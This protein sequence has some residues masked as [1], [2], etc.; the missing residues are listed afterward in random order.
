MQIAEDFL[1]PPG[2]QKQKPWKPLCTFVRF[3]ASHVSRKTRYSI[4]FVCH[5][6]KAWYEW[7]LWLFTLSHGRTTNI[8]KRSKVSA[9]TSSTGFATV[10]S[11][12]LGLHLTIFWQATHGKKTYVP[13]NLVTNLGWSNSTALLPSIPV[14]RRNPVSLAMLWLGLTSWAHFWGNFHLGCCRPIFHRK[15]SGKSIFWCCRES[16][17]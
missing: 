12:K 15:S 1:L 9:T 6:P 4:H 11:I 5:H 13:I 7:Q 3:D 2:L 14:Q 17:I 16:S 10:S 8:S